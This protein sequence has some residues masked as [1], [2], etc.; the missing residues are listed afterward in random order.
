[1]GISQWLISLTVIAFG[2]SVPELATSIIALVKRESDISIGNL[3]GSNIFNICGILGITAIL[4]ELISG[5]PLT[6]S[7]PRLLNY[8][9]WWMLGISSVTLLFMISHREIRRT[10]GVLLLTLYIVYIVSIT[11]N[12]TG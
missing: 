5:A 1:M 12:W 11:L 4:T 8:D 3:I 9:I 6:V 7:D 2:T 10:E